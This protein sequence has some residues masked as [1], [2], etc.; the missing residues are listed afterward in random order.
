MQIPKDLNLAPDL[1]LRLR[2]A[3][4]GSVK[5]HASK[6]GYAEEE[7]L[8]W[9]KTGKAVPS[10]LVE[11]Y[12]KQYKKPIAFFLLP[13]LRPGN[14]KPSKLR[15][16]KNV[17]LEEI[18]K[19]VL[20]EVGRISE[21]TQLLEELGLL[22]T[23]EIGFDELAFDPNPNTFALRTRE[24]LGIDNAA[25][26]TKNW[27]QYWIDRIEKAGVP[28]VQTSL[29]PKLSGFLATLPSGTTTI[30]LDSGEPA[31]RRLFTLA[32]E[33]GHFLL[34]RKHKTASYNSEEVYCNKFA[35]RLLMPRHLLLASA[36]IRNFLSDFSDQYLLSFAKSF[37]VSP[38]MVLRRIVDEKLDLGI[39]AAFYEQWVERYEEGGGD[40]RGGRQGGG[41]LTYYYTL[42]NRIGHTTSRLLLKA[43]S[44][45]LIDT[46][47]FVSKTGLRSKN[48]KKF[49]G[50]ALP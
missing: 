28:V 30:V 47:T 25:S 24:F 23:A 6:T 10:R 8:N 35:G 38:E 34:K 44:E 7:I 42:Y 18:E 43:R 26:K 4:N 2:T 37:G 22:S 29:Q 49:S 21:R 12:R 20:L 17:P 40:Y 16:H 13:E 9:E 5:D 33:L 50:V 15:T 46:P 14:L 32:H 1:L 45:G 19:D 48:I 31:S 3:Y 27:L 36:H 39:N 41:P 11:S